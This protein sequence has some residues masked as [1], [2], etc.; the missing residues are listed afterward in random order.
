[1]PAPTS[2]DTI[3]ILTGA[4]ISKESRLDTFRDKSGIWSTVRREDVATR[5]IRP[6]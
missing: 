2:G 4:G 3:V 6:R 5:G 1:M